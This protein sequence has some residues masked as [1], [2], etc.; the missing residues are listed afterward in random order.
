MATNYNPKNVTI[1]VGGEPLRSHPGNIDLDAAPPP[2]PVTAP[3]FVTGEFVLS[4]RGRRALA[5]LR[6]TPLI[7]RATHPMRFH[8]PLK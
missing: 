5:R 1:T 2:F 4:L 6:G 7:D 3:V 8:R